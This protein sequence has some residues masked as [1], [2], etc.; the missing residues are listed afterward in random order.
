MSQSSTIIKMLRKAGQ[1]GVYNYQFPEARILRYSSRIRE[2]RADGYNIVCE[3]I[4][5]PNGR[6]TSVFR[7][8][9]I[10]EVLKKKWWQ[11]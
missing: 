5:L 4:K 10:E 2:L 11:R 3:R 1:R 7:Y 8:I 6:V 9:L